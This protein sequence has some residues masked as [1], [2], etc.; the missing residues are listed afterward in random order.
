MREGNFLSE[1]IVTATSVD[2]FRFKLADL[3]LKYLNSKFNMYRF[4]VL[5]VGVLSHQDFYRLIIK[6]RCRCNLTDSCLINN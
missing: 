5:I 3:F 4:F 6:I 2:H 1:E